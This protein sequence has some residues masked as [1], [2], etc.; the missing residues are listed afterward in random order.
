MYN[1]ALCTSKHCMGK[2]L[3]LT[4]VFDGGLAKSFEI[5]SIS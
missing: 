1:S 4:A 5:A 3:L 2:L